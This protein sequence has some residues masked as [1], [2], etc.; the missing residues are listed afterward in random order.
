MYWYLMR[1]FYPN[2]S[3]KTYSFLSKSPLLIITSQLEYVRNLLTTQ[4]GTAKIRLGFPVLV[5]LPVL[6][7]HI[8]QSV[9]LVLLSTVTLKLA[10]FTAWMTPSKRSLSHLRMV[11]W[12]H[13]VMLRGSLI[14]QLYPFFL[15]ISSR[16][17][18]PYCHYR[19]QFKTDPNLPASK[20]VR[21]HEMRHNRLNMKNI[22]YFMFLIYFIYT[23]IY[24]WNK[25]YLY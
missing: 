12:E 1:T 13:N 10:L 14:L 19:V 25:I 4:K 2:C 17:N 7:L 3:F 15:F 6:V 9:P 11:S 20:S 18:S 5:N 24:I 16:N 21:P 22:F 8:V 23:K